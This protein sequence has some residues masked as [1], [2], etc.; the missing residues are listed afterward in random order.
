MRA[1]AGRL[2]SWRGCIKEPDTAQAM[3]SPITLTSEAL[4]ELIA[5]DLQSD[6]PGSRAIILLAFHWIADLL[7]EAH[8]RHIR[9]WP[10]QDA[11]G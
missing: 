3:H 8:V 5:R 10:H 2:P 11:G 6:P 1:L 9:H 4:A 7:L